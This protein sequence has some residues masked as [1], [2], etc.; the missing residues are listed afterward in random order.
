M[1]GLPA[2]VHHFVPF[3]HHTV[4][5]RSI[6][7]R[8]CFYL[9]GW[10]DLARLPG[11]TNQQSS[12]LYYE[13]EHD[14][15]TVAHTLGEIESNSL[16]ILAYIKVYTTQYT[17]RA[18]KYFQWDRI[19]ATRTFS[20]IYEFDWN[21]NIVLYFLTG[22]IKTSSICSLWNILYIRRCVLCTI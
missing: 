22:R 10:L 17:K 15:P 14:R 5:H 7:L 20:H 6:W 2:Y 3:T 16:F 13:Y 4:T 12:I 21:E 8:Y 19:L 18:Q 9:V 11:L 1:V